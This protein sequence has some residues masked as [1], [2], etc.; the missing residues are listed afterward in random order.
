MRGFSALLCCIQRSGGA[1]GSDTLLVT[2]RARGFGLRAPAAGGGSRRSEGKEKARTWRAFGHWSASQIINVRSGKPERDEDHNDG[3]HLVALIERLPHPALVRPSG[4]W[5]H[6]GRT[7]R[8]PLGAAG[9]KYVYWSD[10]QTKKNAAGGRRFFAGVDQRAYLASSS[11]A[12]LI[13][14]PS[15]ITDGT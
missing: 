5:L 15:A 11:L 7:Q 3:S 14:S 13:R 6:L 4:P 2:F 8:L 9:P 12:A 1:I 10:P